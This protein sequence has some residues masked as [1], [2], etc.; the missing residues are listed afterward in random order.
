MAYADYQDMQSLAEEL[1]SHVVKTVNGGSL[2]VDFT[3]RGADGR[4]GGK[5]VI[6]FTPPFKKI[7]YL[8]EL[9][10]CASL[11]LQ[12]NLLQ[13]PAT[14][15]KLKASFVEHNIQLPDPA[16][17]TRLLDKLAQHF[18]EAKISDP[19]FIVDHPEVSGNNV[20]L[21]PGLAS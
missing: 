11:D 10:R 4:L 14:V 5:E 12:P 7:N 19:C 13:E 20:T 15:E 1:L 21:L 16:T 2:L 9:N 3:P 6:D 8:E 18:L 17:P